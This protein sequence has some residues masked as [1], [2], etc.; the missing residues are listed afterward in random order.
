MKLKVNLY[1]GT[2]KHN[3]IEGKTTST[4]NKLPKYIEYVEDSSGSINLFVDRAIYDVENIGNGLKNYGWLLES[5]S[6]TKDLLDYFR[7]NTEEKIKNFK[8]IFTHNKELIDLNKK[9]KF[10]HPIGYWVDDINNIKKTKLISMVT[11]NKRHTLMAA[12]RYEFAKKNFNKIDIFGNGFH[13][14]FNKEVGLNPYYFSVV[15]ENDTTPDYFSEKLLDCFATKT[16]PIYF[17]SKN[18]AE[19]FDVKGIVD[20]DDFKLNELTPAIYKD[21]EKH[22]DNNFKI[23]QNYRSPEDVMYKNY[24]VT[25][26]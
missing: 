23:V 17:G 4:Q 6:I 5:H 22:V 7:D 19:Y 14:I 21:L 1:G 16:I 18:I 24:L 11:S 8:F 9:F 12:K 10:L 3:K 2:F 13:T 26:D 25:A 20:F 15:F